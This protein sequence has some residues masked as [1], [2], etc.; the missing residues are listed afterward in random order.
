[1]Q[2]VFG[3]EILQ[4]FFGFDGLNSLDNGQVIDEEFDYF[5]E[6]VAELVGG[7][8]CVYF[9]DVALETADDCFYVAGV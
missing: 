8:C 4:I 9:G 5:Y 6:I 2:F 7:E 1:M 3:Q